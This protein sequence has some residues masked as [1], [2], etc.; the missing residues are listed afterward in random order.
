MA[1]RSVWVSG[2]FRPYILP[3]RAEGHLKRGEIMA[4]R[5][6]LIALAVLGVLGATELAV[7]AGP[8]DGLQVN[9]VN[10]PANPVPVTGSVTGTVG[11]APGS[12]VSIANTPTVTLGSP[13]P[14]PTTAL[15]KQPI[16]VEGGGSV[17]GLGLN[18]TLYVVPAGKRLI[19]EHFSSEAGMVSGTTV[20]RYLLGVAPDPGNP[21]T[22]NFAHFIAPTFSSP[23]GTCASG[24]VEVVASQPIRMYVEAGQAL[25]V[26]VAFSGSVGPSGFA[27]LSVSGYL[28]D[29]N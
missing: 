5:R 17:T 19:V 11:L 26:G 16:Q 12:S 22:V 24:Q 3:Y 9:V 21:S 23:C 2:R 18:S 15:I 1:A 10:M 28:I 8:P 29:A 4:I 27:F 7:A 25:V 6:G 13:I 14:L 20:N